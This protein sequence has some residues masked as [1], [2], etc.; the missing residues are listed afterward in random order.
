MKDA[1]KFFED[2]LNDY[3]QAWYNKDI[4]KLKEFYDDA[5][6]N[7]I[8]YDNHKG[9]DTYTLEAHL[10]LISDF[11]ENGKKT[12]SGEVEE[13]IIENFNAFQNGDSAC[14]CFFAR[15]KSFPEPHVRTTMYLEKIS[16]NWK[17]LHVHCSFAPEK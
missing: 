4:E 10:A 7:L 5:G 2:Y 13:L 3:N 12:E 16:G 17:V 8:Y 11:F 1:Q 15:Y 6:N 14:L 9:N